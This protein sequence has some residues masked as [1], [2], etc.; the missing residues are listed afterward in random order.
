MMGLITYALIML[1]MYKAGELVLRA[2]EW[3]EA[4]NDE[5]KE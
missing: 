2:I 5:M 4:V 3:F 1:G